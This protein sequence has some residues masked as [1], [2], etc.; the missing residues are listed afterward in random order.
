MTLTA[1]EFPLSEAD[2]LTHL[3]DA[4]GSNYG[5]ATDPA[6][7]TRA[8]SVDGIH[9]GPPSME[10]VQFHVRP[11]AT[12]ARLIEENT[13]YEVNSGLAA[14]IDR[15]L[16]SLKA[17]Q[18]QMDALAGILHLLPSTAEEWGQVPSGSAPVEAV[19]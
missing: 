1:P 4:L 19:F 13:E 16:Q 7:L 3:K 12:A 18:R 2:A 17:K 15:K 5:G 8:L 9:D 10:G 6:T 11:W 14:R